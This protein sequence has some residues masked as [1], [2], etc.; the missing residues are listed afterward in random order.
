MRRLPVLLL[1]AAGVATAAPPAGAADGLMAAYDTYVSGSGFQIRLVN[2]STGASIALPVGVNTAADEL[3][4]TL[5]HDGRF[6]V[7]MRTQ[8]TPTLAGDIVPPAARTLHLVD[9]TAGTVSQLPPA[10]SPSGPTF[11]ISS[12]PGTTSLAWGIPH[13]RETQM[14]AGTKVFALATASFT[15]GALGTATTPFT[16]LPVSP[17]TT[18]DVLTTHAVTDLVSTFDPLT[19][20]T[21]SVGARYT[22]LAVTDRGTGAISRS[23]VN[24]AAY[25]V[26]GPVGIEGSG[27]D[28]GDATASAAHPSPR[29]A[30]ETL[31]LHQVTGTEADIK[32]FKMLGSGSSDDP[33]TAP[34]PITTTAAERMPA[35]SPDSLRLGFVRTAST[36]GRRL[37]VFDLTPGIQAL[38]NTPVDIGPS[39]P[40]AQLRAYQDVWGGLS[41]APLPRT[42]SPQLICDTS[43]LDKLQGSSTTTT[44]S[45][46][47]TS[48]LV[49]TSIGIF[50]VRVTGKRTLLGAKV[51]RIKVVGRVP[52]GRLRNGRST[53]RW[54][55]EVDGKRLKPGTYLLTFRS[56]RRDRILSTSGS[57]RFTITRDGRVAKVKRERS[58]LA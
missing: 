51:P 11:A 39:A 31:A 44:L 26:G 48:P 7:F 5:S 2:A 33:T 52:L 17:S 47:T 23:L 20:A 58:P 8:L 6:L 37:G 27:R 18:T 16:F 10:D 41:L 54:P 1:V 45:P 9:R 40:S 38:L 12:A 42:S 30:D 22:T 36:G 21:A 28:I 24:L 29:A 15:S 25:R 35:W 57:V 4:P 55:A 46:K 49:G 19:Q 32:T 13:R 53:F 34:A 56:L 3:H 14:G 43:C 50:V